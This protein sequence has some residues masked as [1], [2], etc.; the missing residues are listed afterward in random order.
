MAPTDDKFNFFKLHF[1]QARAEFPRYKRSVL[2]ALKAR[3]ES[4][5]MVRRIGVDGR[6]EKMFAEMQRDIRVAESRMKR[7]T[8]KLSDTMKLVK[9][10]DKAFGGGNGA[11]EADFAVDAF[12]AWRASRNDFCQS[13]SAYVQKWQSYEKEILAGL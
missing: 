3:E 9:K 12:M 4:I 10:A 6:A 11:N 13:L 7:L 8:E 5:G 1:A 2:F